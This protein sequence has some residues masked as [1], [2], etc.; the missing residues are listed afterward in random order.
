MLEI[1]PLRPRSRFDKLKAL[2][3]SKGFCGTIFFKIAGIGFAIVALFGGDNR[4]DSPNVD[5]GT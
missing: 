3:K 4:A 5:P 1:E 2:S